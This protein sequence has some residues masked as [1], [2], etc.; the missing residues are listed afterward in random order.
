VTAQPD[1]GRYDELTD[2]LR[3]RHHLRLVSP[4]GEAA[5]VPEDL[6]EKIGEVVTVLARGQNVTVFA[7]ETLISTTRA[8]EI[9]GISRQTVVRFIES[10][11]L[12][13]SQPGVHRRLRLSDVLAVKKGREDLDDAMAAAHAEAAALGLD[14]ITLD[15]ASAAV[16]QARQS[17]DGSDGRDGS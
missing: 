15:E 4:E 16:R 10:G 3:R 14:D 6:A 9:L 17:L 12:R 1:D 8:A 11:R 7:D 13:Y 5:D 2:L